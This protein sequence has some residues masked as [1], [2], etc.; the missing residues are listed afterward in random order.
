ME[1]SPSPQ[2]LAQAP[3]EGKKLRAFVITAFVLA[4]AVFI[5]QQLPKRGYPTDLSPIGQ[6]Q[7]A[8]V[9]TMDGNFMAGM[10]MMPVLD[11]LREEF[12]G[13]VQFLVASMGLPEGQA[14][15]RSHQTRDGSVALFDPGGAP[16]LV[17]HG[18]RSAAEL[19]QALQLALQP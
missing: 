13:Q 3:P 11:T 2:A 5:W 4:A 18:P 16:V 15:A 17:L 6:G 1:P 19:R 10:E 8:L 9:L 7:A 14:F 12:G